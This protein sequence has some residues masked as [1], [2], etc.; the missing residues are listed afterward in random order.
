MKTL[1]A[2]LCLCIAC[3]PAYYAASGKRCPPTTMIVSDLVLVG[4]ALALAG[5]H[6]S[7]DR[8]IRAGAEGGAGLGLFVANS[9]V[10][11]VCVR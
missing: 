7:A 3:S 4:A 6:A 8:P 5:L 2:L 11:T 10:E 9:Y 1:A